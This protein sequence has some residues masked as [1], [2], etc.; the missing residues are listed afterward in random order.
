MYDAA[1]PLAAGCLSVAAVAFVVWVVTRRRYRRNRSTSVAAVAPPAERVARCFGDALL[2]LDVSLAHCFGARS[3]PTKISARGARGG[4]GARQL[5]TVRAKLPSGHSNARW[6]RMLDEEPNDDDAATAI[7]FHGD[8]HPRCEASHSA[9]VSSSV[10]PE[11]A[12]NSR[13][14]AS[15][16]EMGPAARPRARVLRRPP[17]AAPPRRAVPQSAVAPLRRAAPRPAVAAPPRR[18]AL[19]EDGDFELDIRDAVF[20]PTFDPDGDWDTPPA[21]RAGVRL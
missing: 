15:D 9:G 4:A 18:A 14:D 21:C 19:D 8:R 13:S 12:S 6:G 20:R 10:G 11:D 1:L 2:W 7:S 3:A 17:A 5:G 16:E